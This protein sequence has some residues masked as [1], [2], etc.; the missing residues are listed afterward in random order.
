M[1]RTKKFV[2]N[3]ISSFMLQAVIMVAGLIIPILMIK[4]YGSEINGLIASVSQF[5]RYFTLVEAGLA[6][7]AIYAL[8]KPLADNDN[9]AVSSI[10]SATRIFY[11]KSGYF[12]VAL[13]LGCSLL[14]PYFIKTESL[15]S[16]Q[17]GLLVLVLGCSGV[18]NFFVMAKYRA[19][20]TADQKLYIINYLTIIS[21]IVNTI[22]VVVLTRM[23]VNIV[24]L[25]VV[26]LLSVFIP[27]FVMHFYIKRYYGFV[28][29]KAKP[30]NKA[31]N[32]RW[33]A[34]ILQ[35]LGLVHTSVPIILATIFTSLSQVS[36]YSI[37][38]MVVTGVT[39]IIYVFSGG[40]SASFGELIALGDHGLFRK[41]YNQ[42]EFMMYSII[43]LFYAV[44][45]VLLLPFI[46]LYTR[47]ITD[48]NYYQP[49]I[50]FLFVLNALL[51]S[52][53]SPQGTLVTSAGLFKETKY[54]TLTQALL[55]I[56]FGAI[57]AKFFELKG[58]LIG[59]IISNLYRDIDLIIFMPK[60]L[61]NTKIRTTFKRVG[62]IL[63]EFVLICLP[64]YYFDM[65]ITSYAKW[66]G[67]ASVVFV[68]SLVVIVL[69]S[70]IF[71]RDAFFAAIGRVAGIL[72]SKRI[73]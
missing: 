21:V 6:S 48:V 27:P 54:Q 30:N 69:V 10:V 62:L 13:I 66:L 18:L 14:Y 60:K 50:A 70:L 35:I 15:P 8:F 71:E 29:Y 2:S 63:V 12:F 38:A 65:G 44:T 3:A 17:V 16:L 43:T 39:Q 11:F 53:K 9:E 23:D 24:L 52:I 58:I 1:S 20:V 57:L 32:K 73:W 25:R 19:L 64:F 33:D 68:Y 42:Y 41:V 4:T 28:N 7:A 37:Y 45:M 47:G 51:Y 61:H 56:I 49:T 72:K 46:K 59:L 22:V 40:I 36:V 34:L 55:A 67:W 31:L 5:V 26:A